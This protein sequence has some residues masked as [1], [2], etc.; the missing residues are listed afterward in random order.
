[1]R[2]WKDI[3]VGN[4]VTNN[5]IGK[6]FDMLRARLM[7]SQ[8][9]RWVLGILFLVMALLCVLFATTGHDTAQ[10]IGFG[11][12]AGLFLLLALLVLIGNVFIGHSRRRLRTV[13]AESEAR[14][15]QLLAE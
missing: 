12:G 4:N 14:A 3:Q 11:I 2:A 7:Q 15:K 6:L 8:P 13:V 9:G 5:L 10:N 1:M